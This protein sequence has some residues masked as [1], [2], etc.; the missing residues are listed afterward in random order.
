MNASSVAVR[1][2]LEGLK[3]KRGP[4]GIEYPIVL[5]GYVMVAGKVTAPP[6]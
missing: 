1:A 3:P 6:L 4:R 5:Y 2:D